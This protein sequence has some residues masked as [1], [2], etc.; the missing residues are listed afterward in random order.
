MDEAAQVPAGDDAQKRGSVLH[1]MLRAALLTAVLALGASVLS[2]GHLSSS[3]LGLAWLA[4]AGALFL[5]GPRSERPD[6]GVWGRLLCALATTA[7]LVAGVWFRT[8]HLTTVP[9]GYGYE[10]LNFVRF[11][12]SLAERG[13]PYEPYSWYAHTLFS[14]VIAG[15]L[16]LVPD[17]ILALRI[18]SALV[19]IL[20]VG[21]AAWCAK[22]LFGW[23]AAWATCALLA[24]STWHVWASRNGYHQFLMP[25][26]QAM[27]VGG[28]V[29]GLR[30]GSRA[31]FV[32]AVAGMILGLHAYWGLYLMPAYAAAFAAAVWWWFPERWQRSRRLFG[33]SGTVAVLGSAP[34][35]VYLLYV[36]EGFPYI[37]ESLAP[38][39]VGAATFGSKIPINLRYL[40][41]AFLPA[42]PPARSS[43]ALL[44]ALTWAGAVAGTVLALRCV[45]RHL[46]ALAPLLLIAVYVPGLVLSIAN[47]FY[48]GSLLLPVYLLAGFAYASAV[49]AWRSVHGAAGLLAGA[50]F[51]AVWV[52]QAPANFDRF[53]R[54]V[55]PAKLRGANRPEAQGYLLLEHLRAHQ[56]QNRFVPSDEPGK[57]FEGEA[58]SLSRQ[59]GSYQWLHGVGRVHSGSVLFPPVWLRE[60]RDAV[61]YLAKSPHAERF[62][63]PLWQKMY[64]AVQQRELSPPAPWP[65]LG[66]GAFAWEIQIPWASLQSR[67]GARGEG[68]SAVG[69]L[70]I[71]ADG[72]YEFRSLVPVAMPLT[73][74]EREIRE[75]QA[76]YLEEGYHPIRFVP[77]GFGWSGWQ[78]RPWGG[79]WQPFDWYLVHVPARVQ[80]EMQPY[81]SRM[82]VAA[83]FWWERAA[84]VPM[85][86]PPVTLASRGGGKL[87]AILRTQAREVLA[88]AAESRAVSLPGTH[89][90][91]PVLDSDALEVVTPHGALFRLDPEPVEQI[92]SL[93]C[94]AIGVFGG[95]SSPLAVCLD[96][97]L[98]VPG[99][100]P[101]RLRAAD[102]E[103]LVRVVAAVRQ[104]EQILL[105]DAALG[106]LLAYSLE[107]TLRWWRVVP[108]LWWDSQLAL[109]AQGNLYLCRWVTGWRAYTAA[110]DVLFHPARPQTTLFAERKALLSNLDSRWLTFTANASGPL[111]AFVRGGGVDLYR[112]ELEH[113]EE[114]PSP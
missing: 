23:E 31:G 82:G 37:W 60:G 14:Y 47:E 4:F 49:R 12:Y 8:L 77:T 13:F 59:M 50:A 96:G 3:T 104:G 103:P 81:E 110:G 26:F 90:F 113:D 32:V 71:A 51:V 17:E 105:L 106:Q 36:P 58:L 35:L 55:A 48:V 65:E 100:Q 11:A 30:D 28:L 107:G 53:V 91:R 41:E 74:H 1:A 79:A 87:W 80:A 63:V 52:Y 43:T 95:G 39:R 69:H 18:A 33:I 20:T 114:G 46:E 6:L 89:D 93:P 10:V 29:A 9:A 68:E 2:P 56:E 76:V 109:D 40:R 19:S 25:L 54:V 108:R 7:A 24:V 21:A 38:E 112:L 45:R 67:F 62:L 86:E 66:V 88:G 98:I 57:D 101:I 61:I 102:G 16:L 78:I 42:V 70:W 99:Q 27:V 44:D 64:G 73:V 85:P 84:T 72:V 5:M 111:A 15:V 97:S 94:E 92:G 75:G 22:K 34:V 83:S